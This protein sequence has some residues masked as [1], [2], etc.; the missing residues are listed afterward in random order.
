MPVTSRDELRW[1]MRLLDRHQRYP[2]DE[3]DEIANRELPGNARARE[4]F[5]EYMA[6][7]QRADEASTAG[8]KRH[9]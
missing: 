9:D 5:R 3:W 6:F 7:A 8:R 2:S 1:L 4:L